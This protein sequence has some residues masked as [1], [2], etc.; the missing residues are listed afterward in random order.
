[1]TNKEME[2]TLFDA[3]Q[4][5]M[6]VYQAVSERAEPF[7]LLSF[8]KPEP[9][10]GVLLF[11]GWNEAQKNSPSA[12]EEEFLSREQGFVE[13]TEQEILQMTKPL[14]Q[15]IIVNKK[16][17]HMRRKPCGTGYTYEIRF[18]AHGFNLSASGK[19]KELAKA[20]M[21]EKMRRAKPD[22]AAS[23]QKT[24]NGVPLT[25]TAFSMFYIEKFRKE[26]V[27]PQTLRTDLCRFNGYLK[28][29]FKEIPLKHITPV[30]CRD[31]LADVES[32][33]RYKTCTELHSLLNRIFQCA[34]AHDVI[35]KNPLS[36]VLRVDYEKTSSTVLTP[37]EER[38]LLDGVKGDPIFETAFALA[39][40]TGLR[41]GELH[42]AVLDGDFIVAQNSKRKRKKRSKGRDVEL[43]EIY[44]CDRLRPYVANGLP[45]LPRVPVIRA[46]MKP[47]LPGHMLKDL[48][49]TFNSR[50]KQLGVSDHARKHFMGHALDK[51]DR[52]YTAFSR[53]YL[54][55]EGKKLNRW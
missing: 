14:R 36:S 23:E 9:E 34:I 18:R 33:G 7:R 8:P 41:P 16:R 38:I 20:N 22:A 37:E 21:L 29:F 10:D 42:T 53:D 11:S 4:L 13:F 47:L 1:M 43:K 35:E 6:R 17:C 28:P 27:V 25:F 46:R 2:S 30:L 54:L 24:K 5:L 44:V 19:T 26:E 55:E 32:A 45:A 50:C 51:V 49:K 15:L 31:M 40:Y 39:L 52:T 48:R 3:I 12:T